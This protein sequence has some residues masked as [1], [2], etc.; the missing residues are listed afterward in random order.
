[1]QNFKKPNIVVSKCLGFAMCRYNGQMVND[2]FIAKLK[3]HVNFIAVCPEMEIGLGVPRFSIRIVTKKDGLH[4]IQP[5]SG[6]EVTEKMQK[7]T[8]DFLGGLSDIDGFIL[9]ER[10]PS[11][12]IK[13]VKI[14]LENGNVLKGSGNGMFAEKVLEAFKGKAIE[15]EGRLNNFKLREHFLTQ[16]YTLAKFR[17]IKK[18][19]KISTL[20][21][22]HAENKF[23]LMAY[24]EKEMRALGKIAANLDKKPLL[25]V[26]EEYEK[27]L[28]TALT[29]PPKRTSTINSLQHIFGF[30]SETV[31]KAEKNFFMDTLELYK[32][33]RI[34]LSSVMKMLGLWVARTKNA[35]LEDQ[36]IFKPY[37]DE[38]VELKDSGRKLDL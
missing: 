1:M 19:K 2:E 34:P 3:G 13:G 23:L 16:V 24:N 8:K 11:C 18:A 14:Y 12:G 35:Y 27:H 20:T 5:Q 33:E 32:D 6:L 4:L 15:D 21:T 31:S 9:K 7:F 30:F 38:L 36:T 10:S 37:P 22:F 25:D 17:E 26:L 29:K 28:Q